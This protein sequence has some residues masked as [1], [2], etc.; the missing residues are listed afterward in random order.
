MKVIVFLA[1]LMCLPTWAQEKD[2]SKKG[3]SK[4]NT[5][6]HYQPV[7]PNADVPTKE[8]LELLYQ[9][10]DEGKIFSG[11]HHNQLRMPNYM[12]DLNRI[13]EAVNGAVPMVWGGDVAWDADKVVQ[14]AIDHHKQGYLISITWHAARPFDRGIVNFKQQTQGKFSHEQWEE[15][16]TEGSEMH[17]KWLA[18]VD[19]IAVYLNQLQIAGVP[20][21]WRPYHEMNGEWFW[22]GARKGDRGFTLLWKMLYDRLTN[23]HKLNNL[24]WVWNPNNPRKHP[25]DNEM[26][27]SLYYP[28]DDYVDVLAADVYHREWFQDTHDQL[29]ELGNEKLIALGEVGELPTSAQLRDYNRY[30]WFMI[31]TS[32]TSDRYNTLDALKDVFGDERVIN[33]KK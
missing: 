27:Y 32:F 28:G 5:Y 16:I 4:K 15:L 7:N 2:N 25:I 6:K 19:S 26:G 8:L 24:I 22:W 23:Y 17:K 11:L 9:T 29:V 31:W 14:M 18:Q 12:Y 10:V 13:N 20:I 30:A 33:H 1:L 21:L 3:S